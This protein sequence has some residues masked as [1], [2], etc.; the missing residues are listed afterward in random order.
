MVVALIALAVVGAMALA[1]CSRRSEA[2]AHRAALARLRYEP[3]VQSLSDHFSPAYLQWNLQ[4]RPRTKDV[5]VKQA[6]HMEA[7][8]ALGELD[9]RTFVLD[10]ERFDLNGM[11][12]FV[13]LVR[14]AYATNALHERLTEFYSDNPELKTI[15]V[16]T[17]PS[18]MRIWEGLVR[19]FD[20]APGSPNP[21]GGANGGQPSGSDTY[22][23]S[24]AA[25]P[26]H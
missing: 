13:A 17:D 12:R 8:V 26:R 20:S 9:R 6:E 15:S 18:E 7:L 3:P 4:G 16:V 1:G 23:T 24:S 19:A 11:T 22:S 14:Q 2:E 10:H 5:M 25:R 21:Q